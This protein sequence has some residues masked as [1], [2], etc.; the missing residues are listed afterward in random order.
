MPHHSL[1]DL[2]FHELEELIRQ[3]R[4][5][6]KQS[7]FHSKPTS[8]KH[9]RRW[10]KALLVLEVLLILAFLFV[11]GIS[12]R[13][14]LALRQKLPIDGVTLLADPALAAS[15]DESAGLTPPP[16]IGLRQ[17]QLSGQSASSGVEAQNLSPEVP[18]HLKK[19][20]QPAQSVGPVTLPEPVAQPATRIMIPSINVD[21]PVG[22]GTDWESLKY[23][24]GH[25]PGTANPGQ[26]GNMVLAAHNDIYGEIF[27]YLPD[28]S[29]GESVTVY[30]SQQRFHYRLT[31][32]RIIRPEQVEVM[33]PTTGPTITLISC[34]PYL[35]DTHRIV[36]F[37]DLME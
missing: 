5:G 35:I 7:L 23:Q 16:P 13:G 29:I 20:L 10:D 17:S 6:G 32:R 25:H 26:R 22:K 24:V 19:W 12:A 1:D 34:Y 3:H 11:F 2:S 31:E 37:G 14:W 8:T 21:A 33:L 18:A 36:L 15:P 28:V 30:A 9:G 27:R 4:A